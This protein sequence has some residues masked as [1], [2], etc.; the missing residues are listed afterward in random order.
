MG[1]PNQSNLRGVFGEKLGGLNSTIFTIAIDF[2]VSTMSMLLYLFV[3][4][5]STHYVWINMH[6]F[7][8]FFS[9]A[10]REPND[11]DAEE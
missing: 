5:E 10:Y 1:V 11:C 6:F 8:Q 9:C 3:K 4:V 2:S 7:N